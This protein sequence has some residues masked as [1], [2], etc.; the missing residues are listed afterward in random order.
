MMDTEVNTTERNC[1][2]VAFGAP[3]A[4]TEAYLPL[5]RRI[6]G[7]LY[8]RRVLSDVSFEEYYQY[9][10]VGL[11]EAMKRYDAMK[12]AAF[13]TYAT[14]RIRGA[15]LNGLTHES[16]KRAHNEYLRRLR[17]ECVEK[18]DEHMNSPDGGFRYLMNLAVRLALGY[19]LERD[20]DDSVAV[21]SVRFD[22]TEFLGLCLQVHGAVETLP[23]RER[24]VIEAHYYEQLSFEQV[25]E[26]L[27]VSKGR[28]S[29]LHR[30][31]LDLL[32]KQLLVEEVNDKF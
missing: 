9:G 16:E 5:V 14:F 2:E 17:R 19:V 3:T 8:A 31:G 1:E 24:N 10:V 32:Q 23:E 18:N 22:R 26:R 15:I 29:Q 11:L 27:E 13:N 6:A 30:A 21:D 20:P 12:H 7:G 25:A 4:G 28:V